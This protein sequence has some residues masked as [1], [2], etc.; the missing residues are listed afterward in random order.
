[1]SDDLREA[2]RA[3]VREL[4]E[5]RT[6]REPYR[7]WQNGQK[8]V[9]RA[10][11]STHMSLLDQLREAAAPSRAGDAT[12]GGA[13]GSRPAAR[14][15]ALDTLADIERG[16][17]DIAV[18]WFRLDARH[19]V[20]HDLRAIVGQLGRCDQETLEDIARR[21][22][23]WVTRARV[24]ADW[25]SPPWRPRA[26]CPLCAMKGSLRIRLA[27]RAAVCVACGETWDS[28]TIGLLADHVRAERAD[29]EQAAS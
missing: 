14:V 18:R 15:D 22:R 2:V 23:K 1:M 4:V 6:H 10:H 17:D 13:F 5:P 19:M 28:A 16:V 12:L 7:V 29:D 27:E 8:P 24:V 20:E 9:L 11:E 21:I 3:D 25:D 26:T